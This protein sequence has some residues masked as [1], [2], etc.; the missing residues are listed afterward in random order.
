MKLLTQE[1]LRQ[2]PKLYSQD[3]K[4]KGAIAYVKLFTPWALFTWYLTEY[5]TEQKLAFGY[6]QNGIEGELGYISISELEA[7]RGPGGLKIERD[8]YF[9]PRSIQ[10]I[11]VPR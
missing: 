9:S 6:I 4:G 3:G 1:N 8:R 5:D 11:L 2:L 10:E 7:V